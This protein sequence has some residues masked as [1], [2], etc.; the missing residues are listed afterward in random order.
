MD[1]FKNINME[2]DSIGNIVSNIVITVYGDSGNYIYCGEH[3]I[4]YKL[5]NHCYALETN[6]CQL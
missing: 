1:L 4:M 5:S 3:C 2:K 6:I